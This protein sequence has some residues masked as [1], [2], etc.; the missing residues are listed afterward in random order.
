[1]TKPTDP[2]NNAVILDDQWLGLLLEMGLAGTLAFGWLLVRSVRRLGR[3][4]RGDPTE[5]G[6]LLTA[7]AAAITAYGVGMIT[8][9]AFAFIQVTFLFFIMIGLSVPAV[10]MAVRRDTAVPAPARPE[11]AAA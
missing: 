10:R 9:D 7:L 11:R 5:H 1:V 4:A 3:A 2:K 8:F 6:W